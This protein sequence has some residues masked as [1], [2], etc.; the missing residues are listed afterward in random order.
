MG[1]LPATGRRNTKPQL[2]SIEYLIGSYKDYERT[3]IR[4]NGALTIKAIYRSYCAH[5]FTV[6]RLEKSNTFN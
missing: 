2:P 6:T 4:A 1:Y 5:V 3:H